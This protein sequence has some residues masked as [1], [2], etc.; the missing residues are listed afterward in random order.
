LKDGTEAE[1]DKTT[2]TKGPMDA[3]PTLEICPDSLPRRPFFQITRRKV[4]PQNEN[5]NRCSPH[6]NR[7]LSTSLILSTFTQI[8]LSEGW[9]SSCQTPL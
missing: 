2:A 3:F 7:Q 8:P 1:P 5:L 4:P 9:A 6:W